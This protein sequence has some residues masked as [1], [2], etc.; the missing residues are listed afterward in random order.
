MMTTRPLSVPARIVT[1]FVALFIVGSV[2]API[3]Q[4]GRKTAAGKADSDTTQLT[5][6]LP[7]DEP[8]VRYLATYRGLDDFKPAKKP[9]KFASLLLGPGEPSKLSTQLVKP[10]GIAVGPSGRLYVTDTAS[11]RVF[12]FDRDRRTMAFVGEGRTGRLAKPI[13]VAVDARDIVYVADATLKRVFGY[14]ANGEASIAIGHDGELDA[15]SGLAADRGADLLYVADAGKHQVLAYS[16]KDGSLIKVIGK[17]G[18]ERGEFNFPTNLF[19]DANGNLYVADTL[20]F[21]VQIFNRALQVVGVFGQLGDSP[22]Q[23]N[24]PKGVAVDSEGHVYV[25]DSSFNNFQVFDQQG[26]LL[27]FV[28]QGGPQPGEFS[29][30]AGMFIDAQDRIYVA[31]QGN[32]R[33]QVFQY[34][35]SKGAMGSEGGVQQ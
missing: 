29:L 33:I 15:P 18:G 13:G 2:E 24:R 25:A 9:S 30:P 19:V 4:K 10:Y 8:R 3:A 1:L 5:W 21:R 17:R 34:V 32:S 14:D 22:G 28:G 27:L 23:L 16:T 20:N 7:P 12:A 31:D 35:K 6:P 11:R 26:Q